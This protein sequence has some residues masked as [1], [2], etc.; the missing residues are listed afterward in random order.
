MTKI[1]LR[2]TNFAYMMAVIGTI[3]YIKFKN[4]LWVLLKDTVHL[5]S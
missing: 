4:K 3:M 5:H 2:M 1:K